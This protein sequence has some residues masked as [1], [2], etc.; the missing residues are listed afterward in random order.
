MST[1]LALQGVVVQ[2]H[3]VASGRSAHSP[4][5]C[6]SVAMQMPFFKALGLD[7]SDCWAGT[8]NVS[9]APHTWAL[10]R[11]DYCFEKLVWTH[12]H[13]AETFSFVRLQL[14]WQQHTVSAW[15]YYP[16]PET[17]TAHHQPRTMVEIIAPRLEGVAYGD[18]V[19]LTLAGEAIQMV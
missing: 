5:P 10:K 9:I 4:Y 16:H 13:P 7:L 1:L 3:G 11:A 6:G 2:G 18:V 15:L 8:M 17:K 19:Q 14:G 12:L